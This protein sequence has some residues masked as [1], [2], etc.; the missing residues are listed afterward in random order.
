MAPSRSGYVPLRS[1]WK[2]IVGNEN[3]EGTAPGRQE[4]MEGRRLL[5]VDV[6]MAVMAL[7]LI[8]IV[9]FLRDVDFFV[10]LALGYTVA[11]VIWAF[12]AEMASV[13]AE[14]AEHR[15]PWEPE[16]TAA[17]ISELLPH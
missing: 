2:R 12:I 8:S 17:P 11:V 4:V 5:W 13:R 15:L 7:G 1:G 6:G 3:G 14:R 9:A 10:G 16:P